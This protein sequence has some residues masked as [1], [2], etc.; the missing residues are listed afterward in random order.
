[1]FLLTSLP[2]DAT[3]HE[4]TVESTSISKLGL[5]QE[6]ECYIGP[7]AIICTGWNI[8]NSWA[9]IA[10]TIALAIAQGGTVTMIYGILVIFAMVGCSVLSLAEL[11][12]VYPTAGGQ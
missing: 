8:C 11:A 3:Q 7:F 10:A 4:G 5:S 9:G 6:T 2:P 1:L 12:S